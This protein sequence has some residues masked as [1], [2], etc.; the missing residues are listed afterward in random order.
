MGADLKNKGDVVRGEQKRCGLTS[1]KKEK[2]SVCLAKCQNTNWA[3]E[4]YWP[5]S[6]GF[7][8]HS[9]AKS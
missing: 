4:S 5:D 3:W 6:P 7:G 8:A 1:L 9:Q 2:P